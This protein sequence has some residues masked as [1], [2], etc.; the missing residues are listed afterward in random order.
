M[1]A[2]EAR[3]GEGFPRGEASGGAGDGVAQNVERFRGALFLAQERG[4]TQITVGRFGERGHQLPE[5]GKGLLN[6]S[7]RRQGVGPTQILGF[8]AARRRL[9]LPPGTRG[10]VSRPPVRRSYRRQR[11][12]SA[13]RGPGSGGHLRGF[14]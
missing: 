13:R 11:Y 1:A 6:L 9:L 5:V 4:D 10:P 2:F 8:P 12:R 14:R 3:F 7:R